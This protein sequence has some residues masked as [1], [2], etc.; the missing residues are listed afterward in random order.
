MLVTVGGLQVLNVTIFLCLRSARQSCRGKLTL[1]TD[2]LWVV[3]IPDAA[4]HVQFS[5]KRGLERGA[6]VEQ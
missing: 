6:I 4:V 2:P 1:G 5:E 3:K